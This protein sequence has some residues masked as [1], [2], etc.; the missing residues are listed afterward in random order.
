MHACMQV[1]ASYG[2]VRDLP[3]K[4]GSVLPEADFEMRWQQSAAQVPRLKE[5]A[6]ALRSASRLVLATDPDREGEAISWHV[7]QE[8]LVSPAG[9]CCALSC[10]CVSGPKVGFPHQLS[11]YKALTMLA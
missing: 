9:T 11:I 6:A 4:A 7:T 3:A 10:S 2:H 1:L 8:L 5:L